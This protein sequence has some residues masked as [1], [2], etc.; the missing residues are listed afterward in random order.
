MSQPGT[1]D[2][3]KQARDLQKRMGRIQKKVERTRLEASA[4]GGMVTVVV[5]GNLDVLEVRI[6]DA[7]VADGDVKMLQGLLVSAMNAAVKKA[8][9]LME[10]E[11]KQV[12][13]GLSLPGLP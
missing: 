2:M 6:E 3:L 12:T 9:D 5:N 8:K 1:L 13:G 4:G 10:S 7:L 11:M